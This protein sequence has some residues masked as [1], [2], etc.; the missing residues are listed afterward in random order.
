MK[1][2][3][4]AQ[5]RGKLK[6]ISDLVFPIEYLDN[7]NFI[8]KKFGYYKLR[9]DFFDDDEKPYPGFKEIYDIFKKFFNQLKFECCDSDSDCD[10][11]EFD[12]PYT[13]SDLEYFFII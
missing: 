13:E 12:F 10:R 4:K 5:E 11:E 2:F 9:Y 6:D 8:N 3:L 7:I 1:R